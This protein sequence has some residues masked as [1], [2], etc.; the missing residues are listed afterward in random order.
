M[1][2]LEHYFSCLL[3]FPILFSCLP[4]TFPQLTLPKGLGN[5]IVNL[6]DSKDSHDRKNAQL[7][8]NELSID[9]VSLKSKGCDQT[10]Q[11]WT[12]V[13]YIAQHWHIC[14]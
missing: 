2:L 1:I 5:K 8:P 7:G 9:V 4:T 3:S 14:K 10:G 13:P 12:Y 11:L 6:A